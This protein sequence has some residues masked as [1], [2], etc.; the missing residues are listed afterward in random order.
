MTK[1]ITQKRIL[2]ID[3]ETT[4]LNP[5][6]N[7][8]IQIAA[9]IENEDG[10]II[11]EF[12]S[13]VRPLVG[14]E[15]DQQAL[16]ANGLTREE[17]MEYPHF[18]EVFRDWIEWLNTHGYKGV[19]ELRYIPAGYCVSF[20]LDMLFEW[21]KSITG[22]TFAYWDHL[23][24][25]AIDPR[26]ILHGLKI[27]GLIDAPDC[28]LTTMCKLF[29]I[30]LKIAH[31]AMNDIRATRELAHRVWR[32]INSEWSGKPWGILGPIT[33]PEAEPTKE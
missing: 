21:Y 1:S 6:R 30:P 29:D 25:E 7:S 10:E 24:F 27:A 14:R 28:K 18:L 19:K 31:D 23:C 9:L 26:V 17:I 4:G 13:Y 3:T 12:K 22:N 8:I 15:I 16:D 33:N 5:Q 2:W 32:R 20:D 11:S